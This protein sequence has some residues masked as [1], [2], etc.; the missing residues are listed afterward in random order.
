MFHP[1]E[2]DTQVF[3]IPFP[4]EDV[5]KAFVSYKQANKIVLVKECREFEV[6]DED[7]STMTIE[8]NQEDSLCFVDNASIKVQ[9]NLY[10][11]DGS[12]RTSDPITYTAG[13]QYYKA[14]IT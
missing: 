5:R 4:A 13:E 11:F 14:V 3:T 12:R 10:F 2:T 6:D 9:I 8:I 7:N 1:G